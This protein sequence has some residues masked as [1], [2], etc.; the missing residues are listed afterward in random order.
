MSLY[1]KANMTVNIDEESLNFGSELNSASLAAETSLYTSR[2]KSN[3]TK[4]LNPLGKSFNGR[5][6]TLKDGISNFVAPATARGELSQPVK[7]RNKRY[8]PSKHYYHVENLTSLKKK[9]LETPKH[10]VDYK[11]NLEQSM[12]KK[13]LGLEKINDFQMTLHQ[14]NIDYKS[15]ALP[16]LREKSFEKGS[17]RREPVI[18]L[19]KDTSIT[20]EQTPERQRMNQDLIV[21][22][23]KAS[24]R[25]RLRSLNQTGLQSKFRTVY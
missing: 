23:K 13:K 9:I 24:K 1:N 7:K 18:H 6:A 8:D 16:K 3:T 20:I 4:K 22:P 19:E 25:L 14:A 12:F 21:S 17:P 5:T 11:H 2:L 10:M 15:N